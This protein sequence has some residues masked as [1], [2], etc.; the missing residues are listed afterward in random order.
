MIA[1]ITAKTIL[2]SVPQPDPWFGLRYSMNLYRGCQHQCIY[3]DSRSACYGIENFEDILVKS[4]AIELLRRELPRKR[5]KGTIGTG[6]MHDPYMPL[7]A[8]RRLTRKALENIAGNRFPVHVITKSDLVLRDTDVLT[9]IGSVYAAVSF[10]IT[11]AD[12]SL[13]AKIEPNAPPPS[14]RFRAMQ[15]LAGQGVLTGVVMMPVLPFLED[16]EG[17]IRAILTRAREAGAVYIVSAFGMTLRDRQRDYYYAQL[18]CRFPGLRRR[19]E[20]RFGDRYSCSAGN[21]RHLEECLR[22]RCA[23]LGLATRMPVYSPH[24]A[25][26]LTLF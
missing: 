2:S 4:N 23:D 13:A 5:L 10:T 25:T 24:T 16:S 21:A 26:Q 6:S 15:A 20:E 12:D 11:T 22:D 8:E 7:E 9:T 3:C 19:Y 14:R 1:E 17:N 18:D